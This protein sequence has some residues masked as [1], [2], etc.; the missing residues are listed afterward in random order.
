MVT[1]MIYTREELIGHALT[2][3]ELLVHGIREIEKKAQRQK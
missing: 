1:K 2:R 3:W